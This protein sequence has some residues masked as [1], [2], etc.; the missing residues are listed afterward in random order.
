MGLRVAG[1]EVGERQQKHAPG[2]VFGIRAIAGA[3]RLDAVA[4]HTRKCVGGSE[5]HAGSLPGDGLIA[6]VEAIVFG[7]LAVR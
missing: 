4:E 2:R 6:L 5:G 1:D 7:I 3:A